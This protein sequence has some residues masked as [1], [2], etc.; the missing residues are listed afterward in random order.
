MVWSTLGEGGGGDGAVRTAAAKTLD[1]R[2]SC[3]TDGESPKAGC[4]AC[5]C[6]PCAM[7]V[8]CAMCAR[9]VLCRF[10]MRHGLG[11]GRSPPRGGMDPGGDNQQFV[12]GDMESSEGARGWLHESDTPAAQMEHGTSFQYATTHFIFLL[13]VARPLT[14]PSTL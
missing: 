3:N 8:L 11:G 4:Q 12:V 14:C 9:A 2:R 6:M 1:R 5:A 7:C 10:E 13:A